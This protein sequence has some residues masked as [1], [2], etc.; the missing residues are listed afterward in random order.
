MPADWPPAVM[1]GYLREALK[2]IGRISVDEQTL[3][4]LLIGAGFVDVHVKTFKCPSGTWPKKPTLK[5]AG[6]FFAA[7]A[8]TGYEA[9]MLALCTRVLGMDEEK[10]LEMCKKAEAAH[11]DR[12]AGVHAYWE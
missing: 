2:Q 10:V 11:H 12:K 8:E 7:S 4:S 3:K 5:Q 6:A 9:Y 1:F